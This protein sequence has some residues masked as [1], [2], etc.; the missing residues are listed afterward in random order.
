MACV[1][2]DKECHG[3][4]QLMEQEMKKKRMYKGNELETKK[5]GGLFFKATLQ[6]ACRFLVELTFQ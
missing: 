1:S 4:R 6:R 5:R 3:K 2:H